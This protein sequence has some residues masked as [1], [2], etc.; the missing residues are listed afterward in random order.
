[1]ARQKP[2]AFRSATASAQALRKF[3]LSLYV[4]RKIK[5]RPGI[6]L[7][8]QI[9]FCFSRDSSSPRCLGELTGDRFLTPIANYGCPLQRR[10][11]LWP[12]RN[13]RRRRNRKQCIQE[14]K[15]GGNSRTI[16]CSNSL[17]PESSNT[18]FRHRKLARVVRAYARDRPRRL[19]PTVNYRCRSVFSG[20]ISGGALGKMRRIFR[21]I[22]PPRS[23]PFSPALSKS[24][25]RSAS[26]QF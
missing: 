19:C 21:I 23:S 17:F 26:K 16:P 3:D 8:R 24:Y 13:N 12:N 1:M 20:K 9:P 4:H 15:H 18:G 2:A 14:R 5:T 10:S 22:V 25:I 7:F 11:Q 6:P